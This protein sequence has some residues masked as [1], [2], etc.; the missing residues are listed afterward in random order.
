MQV[1]AGLNVVNK[2]LTSWM[3]KLHSFQIAKQQ[4]QQ[5][6]KQA[7]PLPVNVALGHLHLSG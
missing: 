7:M 3:L 1:E 4:Q 5:Q 2:V 6:Q